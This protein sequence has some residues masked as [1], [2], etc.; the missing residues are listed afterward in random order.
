[1]LCQTQQCDVNA[2]N[3]DGESALYMAVTLKP[4]CVRS[5]LKYGADVNT[6]T[7]R[8]WSPLLVAVREGRYD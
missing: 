8:G 1:M 3:G 5:L 2:H 7:N 4:E 6:T